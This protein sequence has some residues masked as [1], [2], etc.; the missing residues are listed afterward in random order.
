MQQLEGNCWLIAVLNALALR[1]THVLDAVLTPSGQ[2]G[3]AETF[4]VR[5]YNLKTRAPWLSKVHYGKGSPP[6]EAIIHAII[7]YNDETH[8]LSLKTGV[9]GL[10]FGLPNNAFNLLM[11][12]DC[13]LEPI[14]SFANEAALQHRIAEHEPMVVVTGAHPGMGLASFH[15]YTVIALDPNRD[16]GGGVL[17]YNP[18][19]RGGFD[20]KGTHYLAIKHVRQCFLGVYSADLTGSSAPC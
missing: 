10:S 4:S 16:P 5:L 1:A 18:W 17:F 12:G 19:D 20:S 13:Q 2:V 6:N 3:D 8:H 7:D 11:P 14:G 15:A 9:A